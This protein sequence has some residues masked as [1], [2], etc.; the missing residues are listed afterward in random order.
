M[1]SDSTGS[2]SMNLRLL[3]QIRLLRFSAHLL[4]TRLRLYTQAE[5]LQKMAWGFL[6]HKYL[7]FWM[8]VFP[9]NVNHATLIMYCKLTLSVQYN[10]HAFLSRTN[11]PLL[12]MTKRLWH[13]SSLRR[14]GHYQLIRLCRRRLIFLNAGTKYIPHHYATALVYCYPLDKLH[15]SRLT[16]STPN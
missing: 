7:L 11:D 15:L 6:K 3:W 10:T 14:R 1:V 8:F 9:F 16:Y 4:H 13:V 2:S 12:S 5:E